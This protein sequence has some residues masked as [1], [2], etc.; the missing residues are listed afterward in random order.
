MVGKTRTKTVIALI[1]NLLV[2]ALEVRGMGMVWKAVGISGLVFYTEDSNVL[3][4][5]ASALMV[6]AIL[7]G[8]IRGWKPVPVWIRTLRYVAAC[9]LMVTFLVVVFVLVPLTGFQYARQGLFTG[10]ELYLHTLCPLVSCLSFLFFEKSPRL[11]YRSTWLAMLPTLLYT[12]VL[13]PLN[14]LR[15]V[16][17]PYPFLRVYEQSVQTSLLWAAI[18]IPSGYI[19]CLVMWALNRIGSEK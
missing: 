14:I 15:I 16:D 18:L 19:L 2:V 17:G 9:C 4:M 10:A 1:L 12:A 8:M 11:R 5:I 3:A 13:V 7:V 6:L